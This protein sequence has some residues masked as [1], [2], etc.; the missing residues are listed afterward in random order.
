MQ[1]EMATIA[2]GGL[3]GC[4]AAWQIAN[5]GIR[6]RLYEMRPVRQTPAHKT[7]RLAELVCSNSLKSNAPGAA[8][9]LVKEELRQAG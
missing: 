8:S 1:E 4:E 2:G 9:W 3:A 7:D 6:V 5:H